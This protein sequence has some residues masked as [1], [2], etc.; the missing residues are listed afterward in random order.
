LKEWVRL[1]QNK[2]P[3]VSG[4]FNFDSMNPKLIMHPNQPKFTCLVDGER[5]GGAHQE[6]EF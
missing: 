4:V 3:P 5:R 2:G 6:N 1:V